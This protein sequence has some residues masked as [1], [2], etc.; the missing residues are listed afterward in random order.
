MLTLKEEKRS[1]HIF[2]FQKS[3]RLT[4]ILKSFY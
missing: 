1:V 2:C 3:M 4:V